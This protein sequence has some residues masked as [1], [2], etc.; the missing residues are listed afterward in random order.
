MSNELDY[1]V[2][3][4]FDGGRYRLLTLL[5]GT[6]MDGLWLD[7]QASPRPAWII[8]RRLRARPELKTLVDYTTPGLQP[9]LYFGPPDQGDSEFRREHTAVIEVAPGGTS[10]ADAGHLAVEETVELGIALCD[11]V[12]AWAAAAGGE[13]TRGL[14]P[15]TIFMTGPAGRRRFSVATPRAAFL[16]E[17]DGNY[18]GRAAPTFE[19]PAMSGAVFSLEDGLFTVALLL[20]FAST[21][22]HPYVVQGHAVYNNIWNDRRLP[23]PGAAGL[24]KVLEAALVADPAG[25]IGV[26]AFR[27]ALL[28]L[29]R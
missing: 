25:R 15:E 16:L 10:L 1:P 24:G 26:D 21:Q 7:D 18:G 12:S 6:S 22:T 4:T 27:A 29:V 14:R 11:L 2:G 23:F 5:R 9:L 17:S 20:W 8:Y 28:E 3:L 13:I 19:P